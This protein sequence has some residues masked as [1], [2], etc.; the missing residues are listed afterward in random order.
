MTGFA[1]ALHHDHPAAD[2]AAER[3][4]RA[5]AAVAPQSVTGRAVIQLFADREIQ[6]RMIPEDG[7]AALGEWAV[8][9]PAAVHAA[10]NA[11]W[12]EASEEEHKAAHASAVAQLD[13]VWL[14]AAVCVVTIAK[15]LR[16]EGG[17]LVP[18]VFREDEIPSI[19]AFIAGL[20]GLSAQAQAATSGEEQ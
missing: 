9:S 18:D 19:V 17:P 11:Q 5:L 15:M 14:Q 6:R 20:F 2:E 4:A 16:P 3:A 7:G 10:T 8:S 1:E 12:C 13:P